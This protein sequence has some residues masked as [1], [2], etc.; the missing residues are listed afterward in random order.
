MALSYY[1]SKELKPEGWMRDQLVIEA[2]GLAGNLDKVWADVRDSKWIGGDREGWERVPYWLCGFVPLAYL[3]DDEDMKSRAKRYI[4]SIIASQHPDG[5]LCPC[6]D[7]AVAGYDTWAL[8]QISRAFVIY[9]ECTGD[10]RV[11]TSLYKAMKNYYELLETGKISLF[12]WGKFRWFETFEALDLLYGIYR[13]E[14]IVSLAKI[15]EK[16]GADYSEFED[17]WARPLNKWTFET[18]V[19]NLAEMIKVE[20]M[21]ESL[22]GDAYHGRAERHYGL[23]MKY[24]GTPAGIFTGDECLSGLSP[25][26]GTELCAVVE[27]MYSCKKMYKATGDTVWLERLEKA[28]FNALPAAFS[29]DMWAHQYD[30]MSNQISCE[31]FPGRSVFRTNNSEAHIFGL[32]PN[33]GCCT[34]AHGRGWTDLALSAFAKGN[35]EIVSCLPVPCAL[36]DGGVSIEVKTSYPF[37]NEVEYVIRTASPF[38]FRVRVPEGCTAVCADGRKIKSGLYASFGIKNDCSV[39]IVFEREAAFSPRPHGLCCVTYGSLVFSLPIKYEKRMREY[40]SGDV[41]RR[42]PYCDYEYIGRGEWRYAFGG[43]TLKVRF[44]GVNKIPFSSADPPVVIEAE[45]KKIPWKYEDG[46]DTV[47]SKLP[48]EDTGTE[49][50][51]IKELYPYGCAKLRVTETRKA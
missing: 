13:E 32:E 20:G 33:Y 15:L 8:M 4:D 48:P 17:R 31:I 37:G 24:N 49:K 51:E 50:T 28:A 34:A 1:T 11:V 12:S 3:L 39:K 30:Q 43:D 35:G 45:M 38:T 40:T 46:F 27:L 16:Q 2:N 9:Y 41:E 18:H 14:W 5:W 29:D 42:F 6:D 26:Q 19:V 22:L 47:C 25:I 7:D 36:N 21:T 23:L 44:N 10:E